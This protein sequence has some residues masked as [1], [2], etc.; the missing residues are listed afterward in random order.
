MKGSGT[1]ARQQPLITQKADKTELIK[2]AHTHIHKHIHT[3][4]LRPQGS[5][6]LYAALG[7]DVHSSN[8]MAEA[9]ELIRPH[10]TGWLTA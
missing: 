1:T 10:G 5:P 2:G 8:P 7:S 6:A 9:F 3:H 4:S